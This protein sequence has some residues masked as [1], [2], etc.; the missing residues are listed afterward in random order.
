MIVDDAAGGLTALPDCSS[1][2]T[3]AATEKR[4]VTGSASW[5]KCFRRCSENSARLPDYIA[6]LVWSYLPHWWQKQHCLASSTAS[7][8]TM[9]SSTAVAKPVKGYFSRLSTLVRSCG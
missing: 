5:R 1:A 3:R 7:L 6:R 8:H 2:R 9:F 4:R